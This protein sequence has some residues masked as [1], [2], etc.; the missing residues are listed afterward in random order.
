MTIQERIWVPDEEWMALSS[1]TTVRCRMTEGK[2]H[3][4]CPNTAVAQFRRGYR[5]I[6]WWAY[7]ADHLYGRRFNNGVVESLRW[8]LP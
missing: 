4:R 6:S 8:P 1:E 5:L 7:C 2:T 3:I